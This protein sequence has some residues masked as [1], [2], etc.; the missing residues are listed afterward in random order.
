MGA[1]VGAV[2]QAAQVGECGR[3]RFHV[4]DGV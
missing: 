3:G 2:Q 1:T 4:L